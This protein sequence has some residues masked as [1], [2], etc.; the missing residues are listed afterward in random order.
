MWKK[1]AKYNGISCSSINIWMSN[2]SLSSIWNKNSVAIQWILN[3]FECLNIRGFQNSIWISIVY[4][5]CHCNIC[6]KTSNV[7]VS[8][9][10]KMIS[11][12]FSGISIWLPGY[13]YFRYNWILNYCAFKIAALV[14]IFLPFSSICLNLK[15]IIKLCDCLWCL[16]IV[17]IQWISWSIIIPWRILWSIMIYEEFIITFVWRGLAAVRFC[18]YCNCC[19]CITYIIIWVIMLT[20]FTP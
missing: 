10:H 2:S 3:N 11:I 8:C 9:Y 17:Q 12:W 14:P 4:I 18:F 20:I 15:Y 7:T 13:I 5:A 16:L 6:C 19:I 1:L